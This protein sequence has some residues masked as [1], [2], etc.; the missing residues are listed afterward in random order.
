MTL[1]QVGYLL[2]YLLT[3]VVSNNKLCRIHLYRIGEQVRV[4][5]NLELLN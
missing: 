4:K 1:T 2:T 5:K 3:Y